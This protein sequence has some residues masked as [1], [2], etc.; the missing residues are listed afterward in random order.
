MEKNS[1]KLL[2]FSSTAAIYGEPKQI[3]I[4]EDNLQKPINAYDE[5]KLAIER[6]LKWYGQAYGIKSVSLRYFNVAGAYHTGEIGEY[7]QPETL[8]IP[9]LLRA[10]RSK[11]DHVKIYGFDYP[12][13]D[14]TCIRDYIHIEDLTEAHLQSL[15]YLENISAD[16]GY[17]DVFNIGSGMGFSIIKILNAVKEITGYDINYKF[18][19]RREGD[20]AILIASNENAKIFCTGIQNIITSN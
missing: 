8:L 11:R 7:H 16:G 13:K 18:A 20:F 17:F 5:T 3:P 4:Q 19:P 6:M 1:V 14:G 15:H 9:I 12:T 10:V 2:V